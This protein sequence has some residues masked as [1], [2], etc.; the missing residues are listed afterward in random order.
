MTITGIFPKEVHLIV[1]TFNLSEIPTDDLL[2][3]QVFNILLTYTFISSSNAINVLLLL[4][5]LNLI[6]YY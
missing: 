2:V 4:L 3:Q 1:R 6:V 5:L